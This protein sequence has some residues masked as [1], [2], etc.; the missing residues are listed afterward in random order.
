MALRCRAYLSP[1]VIPAVTRTTQ[2]RGMKPV[3]AAMTAFIQPWTATARPRIMALYPKRATEAE[4]GIRL[5]ESIEG[6]EDPGSIM[7]RPN[8]LWVGP[9]QRVV[10]VI[11]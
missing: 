11:P 2:A 6:A 8:P 4:F 7:A 1:P 5:L 3:D 10:T 9:G